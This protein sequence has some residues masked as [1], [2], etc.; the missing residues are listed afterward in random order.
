MKA[1][2][3]AMPGFV[4]KCSVKMM[5]AVLVTRPWP[6]P[7]QLSKII[8]TLVFVSIVIFQ[9]VDNLRDQITPDK[10]TDKS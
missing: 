6:D 3:R 1:M 10:E 8:A 4:L 5:M 7:N 2:P 9:T